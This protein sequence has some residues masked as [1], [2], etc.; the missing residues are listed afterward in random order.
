MQDKAPAVVHGKREEIISFFTDHLR[1]KFSNIPPDLLEKNEFEL[2]EIFNPTVI[3]WGLRRNLWKMYEK[4]SLGLVQEI[5]PHD[6]YDGVCTKQNFFWFLNN[7]KRLAWASIMPNSF[8][9][10][11]DRGYYLGIN[12]VLNYMQ[13]TEVNDKN[14]LAFLKLIEQFGN[15]AR[16][17]VMQR[18]ESRNLS[19]NINQTSGEISNPDEVNKKLEELKSKLLEPA[20]TEV[21]DVE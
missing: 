10:A 17:P 3:D 21:V 18:I 20:K 11:E 7:P 13:K 1:D 8:E 5:T 6:I 12:K 16:G 19:V 15:R 14:I 2:E 9:M 4:A